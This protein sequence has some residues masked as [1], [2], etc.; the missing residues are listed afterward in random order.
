MGGNNQNSNRPRKEQI[1]NDLSIDQWEDQDKNMRQTKIKQD[2]FWQKAFDVDFADYMDLQEGVSPKRES[3][4]S[5]SKKLE[6]KELEH[7]TE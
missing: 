2:A 5:L 7:A 3:R 4:L 6:P 1:W